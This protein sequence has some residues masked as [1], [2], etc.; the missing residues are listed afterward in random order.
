MRKL[1]E[2]N[3]AWPG[4]WAPLGEEAFRA[5]DVLYLS[6]VLVMWVLSLYEKSSNGTHLPFFRHVNHLH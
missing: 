6:W 4:E 1:D 3:T 2:E 5:R